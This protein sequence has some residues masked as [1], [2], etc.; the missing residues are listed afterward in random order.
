M[1]FD[2]LDLENQ[3][4]TMITT[5]IGIPKNRLS[6]TL[7]RFEH[8]QSRGVILAEVHCVHCARI[9]SIHVYLGMP[10]NIVAD[11]IAAFT[12]RINHCLVIRLPTTLALAPMA[13]A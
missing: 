13:V 9:Q 4:V 8:N 12:V 10:R 6:I 2:L 3:S 7:R 1:F 11:L 5:I